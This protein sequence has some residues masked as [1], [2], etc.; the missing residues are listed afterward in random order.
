MPDCPFHYKASRTESELLQILELQAVNLKQ[1]LSEEEQNAEGFVTLQ[2]TLPLLKTMQAAAPQIVA[3]RDD[4]V[5]GYA[6]CLI[7]DLQGAIPELAP[8]FHMIREQLGPDI[9]YRVMGQICIAKEVRKQGVFRGLY[10]CLRKHCGSL[11]IITEVAEENTRS[12]EAHK[13]IGFEVLGR[14]NGDK[15]PW[16]VIRWQ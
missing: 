12:L 4:R 7:P 11:P 1:A 6:L 14:R 2:H 13:A 9:Q 10:Q 15:T 5:V 8:M 16:Q 3:I